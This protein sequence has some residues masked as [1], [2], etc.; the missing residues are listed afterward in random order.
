MI[1]NEQVNITLDRQ[2]CMM[3]A[4][5]LRELLYHCE[6]GAI[7]DLMIECDFPKQSTPGRDQILL[8]LG[9]VEPA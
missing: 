7:R 3:L 2:E 8:L 5:A 1:S 4:L 6:E 9:K